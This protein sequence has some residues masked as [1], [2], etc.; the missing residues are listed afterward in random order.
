M[1][2]E[3]KIMATSAT[4][5]R[6]LTASWEACWLNPTNAS[7]SKNERWIRIS[8]PKIRPAGMDQLL[9]CFCNLIRLDVRLWPEVA[10]QHNG[11]SKAEFV[12]SNAS[13]C[14]K[15]SKPAIAFSTWSRCPA[16]FGPFARDSVQRSYCGKSEGTRR[17]SMD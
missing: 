16:H 9:I 13:D 17:L 1:T 5:R 8:T 7:R 11:K 4:P 14:R 3:P 10:G 6:G 12:G 2:T 15:I